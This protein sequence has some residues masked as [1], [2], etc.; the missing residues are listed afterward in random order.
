MCWR[1]KR[2]RS[3]MAPNAESNQ[4]IPSLYDWLGGIEALNRLTTRFYEHVKDDSLLAPV[5]AHMGAD[6]P[7]HEA[8]FLAE[9]LAGPTPYTGS[10]GGHPPLIHRPPRR[11]LPQDQ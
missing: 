11:H 5:F 2:P 8:P 6:H 7:S 9:G 1:W 3:N 4:S 10:H